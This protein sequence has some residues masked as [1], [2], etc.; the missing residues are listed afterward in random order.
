MLKLLIF[1]LAVVIFTWFAWQGFSGQ[2]YSLP[3]WDIL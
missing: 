2:P 1:I 3:T